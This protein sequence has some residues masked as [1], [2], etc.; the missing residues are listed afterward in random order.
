[1][2]VNNQTSKIIN[3]VSIVIIM[4]V[5]IS[6]SLNASSIISYLL[7]MII[8]SVIIT[9][10]IHNTNRRRVLATNS[11]LSLMMIILIYAIL[12]RIIYIIRTNLLIEPLYDGYKDLVVAYMFWKDGSITIFSKPYTFSYASSFPSLEIIT[13]FIADVSGLSILSS[14]LSIS[15]LMGI[16]TIIVIYLLIKK[17]IDN[18]PE[19]YNYRAIALLL[20]SIWPELIYQSIVYYPRHYSLTLFYIL[21]YLYI[22][23]GQLTSLAILIAFSLPFSHSLFPPMIIILY[24]LLIGEA[25]LVKKII[26]KISSFSKLSTNILSLDLK[27]LTHVFIALFVGE[28]IWIAY[29]VAIEVLYGNTWLIRA[30]PE[31][32][33]KLFRETPSPL[34]SWQ[35]FYYIPPILSGHYNILVVIKDYFLYL[36]A[37]LGLLNLIYFKINKNKVSVVYRSKILFLL[38]A[39]LIIHLIFVEGGL[40]GI[41]A[42][43]NLSIYIIIFL[44]FI[45]YA[46]MLSYKNKVLKV[47]IT[48]ILVLVI[49]VGSL[50]L[51][52]HR[53]FLLHYYDSSLS[54]I[55][56]GDHNPSYIYLEKFFKIYL[57]P[58]N[59]RSVYTDEFYSLGMWIFRYWMPQLEPKSLFS[60]TSSTNNKIHNALIVFLS[61]T[62]SMTRYNT[63]PFTLVLKKKMLIT[64]LILEDSV[65]YK[66]AQGLTVIIYR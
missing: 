19:L 51:W 5:I 11:T 10:M 48:S 63:D 35:S 31:V 7:S 9:Y 8:L 62:I 47:I 64:R 55:D 13:V 32:L 29:Y 27:W 25:V 20:L 44:S 1:M 52:S 38:P 17:I 57:D 6:I 46:Y 42:T 50:S 58:R 26:K 59:V 39:Y 23:R 33:Y 30:L 61:D 21:M 18:I 15:V 49:I 12:L 16:L 14:A 37:L 66:G 56:A 40:V 24:A 65:I 3:V 36:A 53:T 4:Y 60:L 22:I 34:R 41:Q 28:S 54:F 2:S 43:L 45:A